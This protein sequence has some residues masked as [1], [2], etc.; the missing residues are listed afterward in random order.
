M[1]EESFK[2]AINKVLVGQLK[3]K[4]YR[5]LRMIDILGGYCMHLLL[6]LLFPSSANIV[7]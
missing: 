5:S 2:Q 6:L 4:S 1:E 3:A 7:L